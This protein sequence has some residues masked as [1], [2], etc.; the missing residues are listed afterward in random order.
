M[1][2]GVLIVLLND[3]ATVHGEVVKVIVKAAWRTKLLRQVGV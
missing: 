2:L 1:E 3:L